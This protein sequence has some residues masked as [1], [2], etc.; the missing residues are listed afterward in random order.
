ME[1]DITS[2]IDN[3]IFDC[4]QLPLFSHLSEDQK[5]EATYKLRDYFYFA[6]AETVLNKLTEKQ[7]QELTQFSL[8][9]PLLEEAMAHILAQIPFL[10][11]TVEQRLDRDFEIIR[12][13][14]TLPTSFYPHM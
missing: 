8:E 7:V 5:T 1:M 6:V 2:Y 12:Q 11:E 4:L 14:A 3:L 13:T 10:K 9:D